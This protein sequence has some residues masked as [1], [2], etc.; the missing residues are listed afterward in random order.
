MGGADFFVVTFTCIEIVIQPIQSGLG[1]NF[2]LF[3]THDAG[4][5]AD[6]HSIFL[7]EASD[8][9]GQALGARERRAASRKGHAVSVGA[10]PCGVFGLGEDFFITLDRILPDL[11]LGDFALRAVP[12]VFRAESVLDIVQNLNGDFASEIFSAGLEGGLQQQEK[13]HV[14]AVEDPE[15][16]FGGGCLIGEGLLG[17]FRVGVKQ[18]VRPSGV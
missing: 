1:Q 3:V 5:K 16:F 2:G 17:Q 14:L 18:G 13:I 15:G 12:A 7:L 10:P 9:T 8:E 4:G 6:L 11:G